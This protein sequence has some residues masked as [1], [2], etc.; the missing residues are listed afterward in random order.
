MNAR[1]TAAIDNL[2]WTNLLMTPLYPLRIDVR[3][4]GCR[5]ALQRRISVSEVSQAHTLAGG[6]GPRAADPLERIHMLLLR[7]KYPGHRR[8]C[9]HIKI[10]SFAYGPMGMMVRNSPAGALDRANQ[11]LTSKVPLR[12]LPFCRLQTLVL[13][14]VDGP[15]TW[16]FPRLPLHVAA[17]STLTKSAATLRA[18]RQCHA[19]EPRTGQRPAHGICRA[20][21]FLND[22]R[23]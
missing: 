19:R 7:R 12:Q 3:L 4:C 10:L 20:H 15:P 22:R 5:V 18:C 17:D 1:S 9:A 14:T 2:C 8:K 21:C 6:A 11:T 16:V 13:A 23:D